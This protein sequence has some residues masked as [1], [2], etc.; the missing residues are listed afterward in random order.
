MGGAFVLVEDDP[1]I[2]EG[3]SRALVGHGYTTSWVTTG[4]A[5]LDLV[6]PDARE[7]DLVL[8][9]LGLPDVDGV[10]VCGSCGRWCRRR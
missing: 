2:G 1:D 4:G 6:R 5:A 9:D 7:P 10:A 8:L 3:L